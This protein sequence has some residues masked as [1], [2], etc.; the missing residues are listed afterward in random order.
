MQTLSAT[1]SPEDNK[2]RLYATSRLDPELYQRVRAAGFIW[3]PKQDLFVAPMWTPER[4][5][6]LLELCGEIGDEDT[7]LVDRAE[8]RADRFDEYHDKRKA[9]AARTTAAVDSLAQGIPLGQPILVGHHSERRARKDAQRIQDGTRK[10]IRLW[11]TAQ[12]WQSRAIGAL[13]HAEYKERPDVRARRIKGL[14]A[15]RRKRVR[16]LTTAEEFLRV[17]TKIQTDPDETSKKARATRVANHSESCSVRLWYDLEQDKVTATEACAIGIASNERS[18]EIAK[19]WIEHLDNRLAY[20]RT[21]LGR[22]PTQETP[23]AP[24]RKTQRATVKLLNYRGEVNYKNPY[25][26]EPVS[27]TTEDMTKAEWARKGS[28]SKC[29]RIAVDGSHKVRVAMRNNG[30]GCYLTPVF[31]TDSKEHPNP[32][33]QNVAEAAQ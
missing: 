17:W 14:E 30:G 3:A 13:R 16:D 31:I 19:R 26:G 33:T 7:S 24:R 27:G 25:T 23:K 9:D 6:L 10:A 11:N 18:A 22:D 2:L 5:D 28:D 29:T 21:L 12:Y 8:E 1:Y 15:D 32:N 20:E 4:E